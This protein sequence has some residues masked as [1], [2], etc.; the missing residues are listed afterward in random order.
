MYQ[1]WMDYLQQD[2]ML[3]VASSF[4][5]T[6]LPKLQEEINHWRYD[7]KVLFSTEEQVEIYV[8]ALD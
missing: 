7:M 4:S 3:K 1:N 5:L 2:H 8:F 6:A